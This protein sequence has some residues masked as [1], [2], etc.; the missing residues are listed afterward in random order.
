[1]GRSLR[2]ANQNSNHVS[3]L[4]HLESAISKAYLRVQCEFH[5][6]LMHELHP[7]YNSQAI[8]MLPL[9]ELF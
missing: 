3:L 6:I 9:E 8:M 4:T 2:V 7:N 1:M 5:T